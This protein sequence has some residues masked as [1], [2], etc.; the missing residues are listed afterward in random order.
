MLKTKKAKIQRTLLILS[1]GLISLILAGWWAYRYAQRRWEEMIRAN[2]AYTTTGTVKDKKKI[3]IS[4]EEPYYINNLDVKIAKEPGTEQW[5]IYF[6]I[7]NF[8]QVPE[9]KRFELM[10]SETQRKQRL[11]LRFYPFSEQETNFYD[12]TQIGD[13][14]EVHYKY[15]GDK[16][17]II[18]IE[19]LT[20]PRES[21]SPTP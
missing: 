11:G 12:R 15:I 1:V 7:D 2:L 14:L 16:K 8:N 19:N 17:E 10:N 4:K 6:E 21:A 5:R 13:K 20:H 3:V 18:N 9:P